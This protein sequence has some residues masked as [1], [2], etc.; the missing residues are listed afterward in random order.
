MRELLKRKIYNCHIWFG[1]ITNIDSVGLQRSL[2]SIQSELKRR[3]VM[4]NEAKNITNEST[5]D[6]YKYQK[7]YHEGELKQ[8]ISHLFIIC[9]E[10]AELKQQQP[11]FMEELM[12]VSRI[13]RSLGVHLILATQ[14]PSGIVND[15]I[16]S[17]S[18]FGICLKVQNKSDSKDIIGRPDAAML[19]KAGQF[20]INVGNDEYFAVGQSGYTGVQYMPS[21]T[22]KTEVDS[23]VEFISNTGKVLKKIEEK[24][25]KEND[26]KLGDQL[27]NIVKYVCELAERR[28]I[29]EKQLWLD[30]IPALIF[31]NELKKKY[32]I[33]YDEKSINP[34]IGEYDD[35]KNQKQ[36]P[37]RIELLKEGNI[38]IFGSADSGKETLLSTMIYE[39][40]MNYT[41]EQIQFYILDFGSEILKIYKES[42]NVGDVV[43]ADDS[44]KI[45]RL[46]KQ[47][48]VTIK[49]RKEIL[50]EY[51]G[52]FELYNKNQEKKLPIITI[53]LNDFGNFCQN[54]P[55]YDEVI[56]IT[57]RDCA[58]F[59]IIFIITANA[60]NEVR[61]NIQQ[62]FNKKITLQLVQE[63]Y[64]YIFNSAR[65]LKPS[66][67]YGRG[68]IT[69]D[70]D[71]AFEFQTARICN[72]E[73][74]NDYVKDSIKSL[75]KERK[76]RAPKIPTIPKKVEVKDI[77][78]R[79]MNINNLPIGIL[80]K[81]LKTCYINLEQNIVNIITC[82]GLETIVNFV[83]SIIE[84]ISN[85]KK[86]KLMLFDEEELTETKKYDFKEKFK[87]LEEIADSVEKTKM[88]C[89]II[90]IDKFIN[91]LSIDKEK[92]TQVIKKIEDSKK[93]A[94]IIIDNA[95]K[96]KSHQFDS[97]YKGFVPQGNGIWCGNGFDSQFI[98]AYEANRRE[99]N[100]NCGDS[101]GYIVKQNKP[102]FI[103]IV[104][105][106]E[107]EEE[108]E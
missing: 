85:M 18:K 24:N 102:E 104:G 57:T 40:M 89:L 59:G 95:T 35:P 47:L 23:S 43:L 77:S 27:T 55:G 9:D 97:W 5:I 53:V 67:I 16:R 71:E 66:S 75:N 29:K 20:Y 100:A 1:T 58:K 92:F 88:I 108:D 48:K 26:K 36:G 99:I 69:I 11:E 4:F 64:F 32:N 38:V 65:R 13:G 63:D 81:N 91:N 72:P 50:S 34:I 31:T 39:S 45:S 41:S 28:G 21:D 46:F 86:L 2:A 106:E 60:T 14:K 105:I 62:N 76:T 82:K 107:K 22:V 51:N 10:F 44:E 42:P 73:D 19:K 68:L 17:N 101:F 6:I 96:L 3:Q 49:E 52:D 15:Q 61:Y 84:E 87:E 80:N 25:K 30:S 78:T 70:S 93:G 7:L 12:S 37:V 94:F 83:K 79:E 98:I 56:K 90:G 74:V 103:K 54:Y 33:I 8:P